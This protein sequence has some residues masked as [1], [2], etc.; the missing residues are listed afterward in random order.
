MKNNRELQ[1]INWDVIIIGS[2]MGGSVSGFRLASAGYSVL[3][4][5]KG[6]LP[7]NDP[8]V[9]N[10]FPE[11]KVE[12]DLTKVDL[13]NALRC[14]DEYVDEKNSAAFIPFIG[15]GAGGSTALYGMALERFS[16]NDFCPL[17]VYGKDSGANIKENWPIQYEDLEYYYS[18]IENLF[19]VAG[20]KD[21]LSLSSTYNYK[22]PPP[23]NKQNKELVHHLEEKG[24]HPYHL[25]LSCNYN[26]GNDKYQGFLDA[27]GAKIDAYTACIKPAIKNHNLKLV[28]DCEVLKLNANETNISSVI[29]RIDEEIITFEGKK[30]ILAAGAL[31]T[32]LILLASKSEKWK[33]GLA[34]GSGQVGKNLMRHLIDLFI[35]KTKSFDENADNLK[36]IG[37]NDFYNYQ[38]NKYGTVQSFGNMTDSNVMFKELVK[39]VC[40]GK[41]KILKSFMNFL[42]PIIIGVISSMFKRGVVL[43]SIME[44]LPYE[45]NLVTLDENSKKTIRYNL[46]SKDKKR[47]Q[48]FLE[49]IKQAFS[50]YSIKF[51][52][53]ATNNR[54]IAHVCGTCRMGSS[55]ESSVVDINN[56]CHELTNLYIL[57]SSFFPSSGAKN[58]ALTIAA[59]AL[60]VADLIINK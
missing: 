2:G 47:N 59:N 25:P 9:K 48:K 53:Q 38:G 31:A 40:V 24:F 27:S 7:N 36:Q 44:D 26:K 19:S 10:G 50:P 21:P 30:I 55:P 56:K 54:R 57:D 18:E 60:R 43:A 49:V 16:K 41:K 3:M 12:K 37:F 6:L 28:V 34:N 17:D 5:E 4:L 1:Q 35:I 46:S 14:Y 45:K 15:C 39:E 32:P 29:C 51:I 42:K 23:L 33:N 52:N 22:E 58:P 11:S 13:K 20:T 8:L